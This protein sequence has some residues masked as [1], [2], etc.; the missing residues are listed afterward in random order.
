MIF[1]KKSEGALLYRIITGNKCER[2]DKIIK[3][4]FYNY[5]CNS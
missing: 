4:S 5:Q 3:V 2:N 1:K